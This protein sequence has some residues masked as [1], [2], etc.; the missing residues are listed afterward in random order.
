MFGANMIA[1]ASKNCAQL[2]KGLATCARQRLIYRSL[3]GPQSTRQYSSTGEPPVGPIYELR[4]YSIKPEKFGDFRQLMTK[5]FHLRFAHSNPLGY[6]I[7]D[8][9]GIF[10]AVH[11]WPYGSVTHRAEVRQALAK[12]E[13]W[14]REFLSQFLPCTSRMD[15]ALMVTTPGTLL[16]TQFKPSPT[17][18]YEL[19]ALPL[20]PG[21]E[22][23]D[24]E[25]PPSPLS[26]KETL[27]GTFRTVYGDVNT[28]YRLMRYA[29]GDTAFVH[30]RKR[31]EDSPEMSGYSRFM[32]PHE[33]SPLK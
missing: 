28:E 25:P 7:A 17:A 23:G 19:L 31:T 15:N 3:R 9:G 32:V 11:I 1:S 26:E 4:I 18:A 30:A 16:C 20:R 29:D 21:G 2:L 5:S 12:D 27:V 14:N 33:H 13:S 24:K 10:Q 22:G 8:L 6:W